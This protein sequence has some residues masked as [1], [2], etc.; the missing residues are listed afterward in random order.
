MKLDQDLLSIQEVRDKLR[1]A[2]AAQKT[3]AEFS[4]EN[5]DRIVKN[6]CDA[7]VSE[8][9]RLARMAVEETGFGN[10]KDKITKN[11]FAARQVYEAIKDVK[12]VG[13][14]AED[15]DRKVWEIAEPVG[16]VAGI[17]PSTNPTST[18]IFKAL[19]AVKAR[20]AIVFSPH[21]SALNCCLEAVRVV[22]EAAVA[23]GA[24]NDIIQCLEHPTL[25]ATQELM[26]HKLTDMLLATGGPGMVKAAYSSGKPAY[27]VG[28]GNVPVFVH[29]SADV[30]QAAR[31]IVQ[32]KSFDYGTICASEQAVV[33]EE[34][35]KRLFLQELKK[36]G[37]QLL[38]AQEKERVAKVILNNRSLNV[39]IVGKPPQTLGKLSGIT[40][41]ENTRILVGEEV[42]VG[43]NIPF[44]IEKLSP[45]LALY[46]VKDR[47][48]G[49][50]LCLKLLEAGGLG[51]TVGIHAQD[52]EVIREFALKKPAGRIVVNSGTTFGGIGATTGIL[53]SMTLGCGTYGNNIT[54]DNI[55]PRHLLNIKRVAFGVREM[56]NE[57]ERKA[58]SSGTPEET[59]EASA[60][61]NLE[62]NE[63]E[64]TKI[65]LKVI[66]QLNK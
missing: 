32:S 13:V 36:N 29:K 16:V 35:V 26:T 33:V 24:P 53:P 49:S 59:V 31:Q 56:A 20:N 21:P 66:S 37:A 30:A 9:E 5:I 34:G 38:T 47:R 43:K 61:L 15:V 28:P 22:Q 64:I 7:A 62:I 6:I 52:D 42:E 58:I 14:I 41:S 25:A 10:V 3:L 12:T 48:E 55:G 51:H 65:I 60:N 2:S 39:E 11:L 19:I 8:A 45:I 4:Q 50:D 54:T 40:I 1:N 46:T 23:A 44:S 63:A 57:D 17:L 18:V 27:G